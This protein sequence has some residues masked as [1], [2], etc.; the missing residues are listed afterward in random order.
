ML[1]DLLLRL[2]V[3]DYEHTEK[4]AVR[5]QYGIFCGYVGIAVNLLLFLVKLAA[6]ILSGSIAL[7]A[8]AVNNLSDSGNSVVTILGFKV[9]AKPADSGHPFGH[10]RMEYIAGVVVSVVIIAIGLNFLKESVLRIIHPSEVKMS[11]LLIVLVSGTLVFKVWLF[12]FYRHIG[13]RIDS[14]TIAAGA[15]DSLCDILETAVVLGAVA[16]GGSCSWPVDGWAGVLAAGLVLFGGV[17]ILRETVDPLLGKPPKPEMVEELKSRLLQFPGILGIHDVIIHNYGPNQYFA[18]AHAEVDLNRDIL[19]VHDLLEKAQTEI[20]R[21]LPVHLL[22]HCD[23]CNAA[24]PEIRK[25]RGRVE[26]AAS[27]ADEDFKIFDLR[28]RKNE[29]RSILEFQLLIPRG[30]SVDEAAVRAKISAA[31][32]Q[33]PDLPE[34]NI[35][36]TRS[37]V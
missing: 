8:D 23:P 3:P 20:G 6:G 28:L 31:L 12:F 13:R 19:A 22:L 4:P 27:A 1:T 21:H 5:L 18:T 10:G 35:L 2:F 37:Y 16:L 24:D 26:A 32:A 34:L 17:R 14:G 36:F 33:Y 30:E 29:G 15:F 11:P 9:A 25:W 7:A